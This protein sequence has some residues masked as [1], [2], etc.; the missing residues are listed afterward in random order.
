M[1]AKRVR[2][3]QGLAVLLAVLASTTSDA[4]SPDPDLDCLIQPQRDITLSAAIEGVVAEILVERGDRVEQGQVVA[5]LESIVERAAVEVARARAEAEGAIISSQARLE[6]ADR[7]FE[8]QKTLEEQRVVSSREVDEAVAAKRVAEAEL[9]AAEDDRKLA[10]LELGR[11]EAF[12]ERRSIR[13]PIDGVVVERILSEG[14]Y[15]DPPEILRIAQVDPLRVEVYAPLELLGRIEKGSKARILPEA[16][17]G[18]SYEATV[19]VVDPVV[20]A[21]S[22]TFGVRL[23]LP[24]PDHALAAG[25]NCRVRFALAQPARV[26]AAQ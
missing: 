14:E 7:T 9:L 2:L 12:L 6:L 3:V 20:D 16:P 22:G 26:P 18:G 23:E 1:R 10:R 24:N 15:A 21:A 17:V 19:T 25:L 11:A 13:S 4:Q 8:R 5:R